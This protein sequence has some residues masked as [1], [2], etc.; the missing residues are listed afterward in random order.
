MKKPIESITTKKEKKKN[1]VQRDWTHMICPSHQKEHLHLEDLFTSIVQEILYYINMMEVQM[2]QDLT[3]F[4]GYALTM[5]ES[6][7][8]YSAAMTNY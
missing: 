6:C 5:M 7:K 8:S 2:S 1:V 3:N 4:V